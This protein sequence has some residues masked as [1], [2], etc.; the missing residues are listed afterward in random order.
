MDIFKTPIGRYAPEIINVVIEIPKG[1]RKRFRYHRKRRAF[2]VDY[3][4]M[5]PPP[6]EFGWVP[7]TWTKGGKRVNAL[8][9]AQKPTWGGNVCEARPIGGLRRRD[10]DHQIVCVLLSDAS[11]GEY[12]GV[13]DLD[14]TTM[15][16]VI[17]FYEP[18][19]PLKG[20]MDREEALEFV[21][22]SNALFKSQAAKSKQ[23]SAP[24]AEKA[25]K[26]AKAKKAAPE[27][28]KAPKEE[29]S[30][31]ETPAE[32]EAP[33]EKPAEQESGPDSQAEGESESGAEAENSAETGNEA[34]SREPEESGGGAEADAAESADKSEGGADHA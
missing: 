5:S 17:Q 12:R 10:G 16:R 34:E 24:A 18:F 1:D 2:V 29:E 28:P 22:E 30:A 27:T 31:A 13:S 8:I 4:L 32:S 20:W 33:A 3:R 9:L 15:R 14:E 19:F 6:G 7:Q 25:P 21:R 26:E 11:S 23:Q